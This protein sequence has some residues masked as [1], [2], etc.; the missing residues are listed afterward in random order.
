MPDHLPRE[1]DF[2][3]DTVHALSEADNALGLLQGIGKLVKDPELLVG[4]YLTR[5]AVASTRIE[6]TQASLSEVLQAE[7]GGPEQPVDDDVAEVANYLRATRLAISLLD[8]LPITG[9]LIKQVHAELM[10]GVRGEGRL[11]GEFR[12]TPVWVGSPTDSPDTAALVPPLP[13]DIPS[14]FT[15]LEKFVNEPSRFS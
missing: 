6:G 10:A 13:E 5:E 1:L 7:A 2:S 8:K 9:R 3:L 4:P 12:R 14:L 11:P 15:D